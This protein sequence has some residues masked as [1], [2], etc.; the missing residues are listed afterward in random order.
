[1]GFPPQMF[2][3]KPAENVVCHVCLGVFENPQNLQ[4]GHTFCQGCIA[5]LERTS[6]PSCKMSHATLTTSPNGLMRGLVENLPIRCKNTPALCPWVGKL[7]EWPNH[8]K[9]DCS[10]QKLKKLQNSCDTLVKQSVSKARVHMEAKVAVATKVM[11]KSLESCVKTAVMCKLLR[12]PLALSG[13]QVDVFL[14]QIKESVG[15]ILQ[16][17][18]SNI[19]NSFD[20]HRAEEIEKMQSSVTKSLSGDIKKMHAINVTLA[21]LY[22][23]TQYSFIHSEKNTELYVDYV[24]RTHLAS[25]LA[26][27]LWTK[28][29]GSFSTDH[30]CIR[31]SVWYLFTVFFR[32]APLRI[33]ELGRG[34]WELSAES[35]LI[36]SAE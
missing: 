6:C 22:L 20:A 16:T 32:D 33:F 21:T 1:M 24:V 15:M 3:S 36:P 29:R 5:K 7:S 8:H 17:E 2:Q 28:I 11:E 25:W 34:L 19:L 12:L 31:L 9:A 26:F 35:H 23:V 27:H 30:M 13:A 10:A 18:T 14:E 4:C